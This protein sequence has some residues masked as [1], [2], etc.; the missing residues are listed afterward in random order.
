M[1]KVMELLKALAEKLGTTVEFL[2]GTLVKQAIVV[3][4]FDSIACFFLLI[5]IFIM[6]KFAVR[7]YK[8]SLESHK[9]DKYTTSMDCFMEASAVP[10][11]LASFATAGFFILLYQALTCLLNPEYW[12]L[13]EVLNAIRNGVR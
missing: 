3:G 7:N 1:D 4:I 12:A 11:I 5:F 10:S 2:W 8:N 13:K 6:V 9:G